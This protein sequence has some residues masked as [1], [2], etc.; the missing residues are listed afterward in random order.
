[1]SA[2]IDGLP[3]QRKLLASKL[4]PPTWRGA[5]IERPQL[6]AMLD[7]VMTRK[8]ALV[9]APA[10]FGKTTLAIQWVEQIRLRGIGVAWLSLDVADNDLSRFLA[11]LLEAVR[12]LD[13]GVGASLR[14]VIEANPDA[15][16]D[17][18]LD[19]LLADLALQDGDSVLFIDDW[20]LIHDAAVQAVVQRLL[21]HLPPNLH[22]VIT[23]RTR[24]GVPLSRLRVHDLLVEIDA[25]SLRFDLDESCIFLSQQDSVTLSSEDQHSLW[26]TTEGWAAALHLASIA[27]RSS[28][29]T[30]GIAQWTA[31]AAANDIGEYLAENVISRLPA[32]QVAFL[33]RTSI[34]ERLCSELCNAVTGRQDGLAQLEALERQELFLQPIGETRQWFRYH[35][36]FARFLQRRLERDFPGDVA[37]LHR[38]AAGWLSD[39]G[40]IV[41]AVDHALAAK[42]LALAVELLERHAMALVAASWMSTLLNLVR[43]LP[44]TALLDRPRLQMAIAW[45]HTLTHRPQQAELAL[46]HVERVARTLPAA[47]QPLLLD[48]VD[49]VR[50][51]MRAY[52]DQLD[53][54]EPLVANCLDHPQGFPPLTVGVAANVLSYY[55]L[56]RQQFAKVD[57]LL[58]WARE[59]HG[60]AEGAFP[61]VYGY[62]FLGLTQY[63]T[64]STSQARASYGEAIDLAMRSAGR[65][66]N[67]ARL[68]S[69]LLGQLLYEANELEESERLIAESRFLGFEGGVVDFYVA[70][71]ITGAR[72]AL[73]QGQR[74]EAISLLDEGKETAAALKLRRLGAMIAFER[75][76]LRVLEGDLLGADSLLADQQSDDTATQEIKIGYDLARARLLYARGHGVAAVDLVRQHVVDCEACGWKS[77]EIRCR[78]VLALAQETAGQ[79]A[80]AEQ[81]LL[82]AIDDGISRN[83]IR[84]FL[85]EGPPLIAIL[86]RVRDKARRRP[87]GAEGLLDFSSA[88]QRVL[89]TSRDPREGIA[90][91]GASPART[92]ER[93]TARQKEVLLHL[94]QHR[95]NKE[96]ARLL[97]VSVDTIKW[98]LKVIFIKLGVT[99]REQAIAE[100]ARL[101]ARQDS[102]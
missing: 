39:Q 100:M 58:L 48:E 33:C 14:G 29:S 94:A 25:A 63:R 7:R 55:H 101:Q 60:R 79:L 40:E 75:V 45:A 70:T 19:T 90:C 9:H 64:G 1:M 80:A 34:L 88:A 81:S 72:L 16:T 53:G 37:D 44:G 82:R 32:E 66:S 69:A 21:L 41:E 91:I 84:L 3:R 67:S 43:K 24:S 52:G 50:A 22:V 11:Y 26:R 23:S 54:I 6:L 38:A 76:R 87:A 8:L 93:F 18:V 31:N 61:S 15:V 99:H 30:D 77:Q 92:A 5:L 73:M 74:D 95:S 49:V 86:E 42:D 46:W 59:F 96:I 57:P 10:G 102:E 35:H 28:G 62:C 98:Y 65:Q 4:R 97:D 13:G 56:H 47:E 20:H 85:D 17:Y 2:G 68:A 27:L 36:L 78:I 12:A 89:V 51:C 71:Y 83:M